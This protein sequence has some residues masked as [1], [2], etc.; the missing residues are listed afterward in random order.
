MQLLENQGQ[1]V[2]G[3]AGLGW[4]V[5]GLTS[6]TWLVGRVDGAEAVGLSLEKNILI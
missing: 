2:S 6:L 5:A 3:R 1:Q 4:R